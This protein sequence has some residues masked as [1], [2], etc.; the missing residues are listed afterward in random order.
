[1][2]LKSHMAR[3]RRCANRDISRRL[4][5]NLVGG[6]EQNG[7]H[8]DAYRRGGLEVD[9]EIKFLWPLYRQ[10]TWLGTVQDFPDVIPHLR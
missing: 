6:G 9:H 7:R 2:Q 1:M 5:D 10:V 4:L 8:G 3:C